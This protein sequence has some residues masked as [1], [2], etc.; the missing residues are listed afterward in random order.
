MSLLPGAGKGK[1]EPL[2]RTDFDLGL[3]LK[4]EGRGGPTR[5]FE[6]LHGRK[7][8]EA[9]S[10]VDC[11]LQQVDGEKKGKKKGAVCIAMGATNF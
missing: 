9:G 1:E 6:F 3:D 5:K 7:R 4:K 2:W 10:P 8:G 11:S